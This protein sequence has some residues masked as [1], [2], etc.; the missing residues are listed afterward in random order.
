LQV[1][2]SECER[3]Q[4][5]R[6]PANSTAKKL[7]ASKRGQELAQGGT[8][9]L[10]R[11]IIACFAEREVKYYTQDTKFIVTFTACENREACII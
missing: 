2:P 4:S 6:K 10:S 11:K 5:A 3:N 9:G 8:C 1:I 7:R